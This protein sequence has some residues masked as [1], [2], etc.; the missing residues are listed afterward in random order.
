MS[1]KLNEMLSSEK[2][3]E[4]MLKHGV[5]NLTS[6]DLISIILKTGIRNK[7]VREIA[8]ELLSMIDNLNALKDISIYN[9]MKINGIGRAKGLALI[10]SIELGRRVYSEETANIRVIL[11]NPNEIYHQYRY[12]FDGKKQEC[13]YAF[14]LDSKKKIIEYRLLFMGT[15]N[16]SIIHPREIF[17]Y[18]YMCSAA[19]IICAHNHPSGDVKPSHEDINMSKSLAEIGKIQGILV[20]DH[21]IFGKDEYYSFFENDSM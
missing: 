10:A 5:N 17:K 1:I 2:P 18:A 12:L 4:R 21:I 20:V 6:E 16:H 7:S 14:Y 15:L 8:I 9:L 13:F 3:R 11:N 19:S